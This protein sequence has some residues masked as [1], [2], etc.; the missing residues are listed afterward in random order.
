MK[1]ILDGSHRELALIIQKDLTK[2]AK[3]NLLNI[4]TEIKIKRKLIKE[5]KRKMEWQPKVKTLY[6]EIVAGTPET[7]RPIVGPVVREAAEKKC[8][9]RNGNAVAEVDL[10][11][12]MFEVTPP[13]FQDMM[14]GDLI[15]LGVDLDKYL[16]KIKCTYKFNTDLKQLV[17]QILKIGELI[18]VNCDEKAIWKV[19]NAYKD[20]Y[21]G[22]TVT[23]RTTT[24]PKEKRDISVRYLEHMIP[25]NPDPYTTAINEDLIEKNGEPIHM[26]FNEIISTF[27]ILGWGVDLDVRKGLS[28]IWPFIVPG[29]FEPVYSMSTIPSS[30]KKHKDYFTRHGLNVF[31][32]FGLDFLNN[33]INVYFMIK[34][35]SK[36][37]PEKYG[38]L[39]KELGFELSSPEVMNK[40][41]NALTIYY[42]FSWDTDRVERICFG[43]GCHEK[44]QVPVNFHPLIKKFVENIPTITGI[45]KFIYSITFTREGLFFK[46]ENDYTE[47]MIELLSM[48]AQAGLEV[49]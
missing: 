27:E 8:M 1:A 15:R 23:I 37:T 26:M 21:T 28:K 19:L 7:V 46:V 10:V 35:P 22:S 30:I 12:A 18:E 2:W 47:S 38:N 49:K 44:R 45:Q 39:L 33:T 48:G 25:H 34:D 11:I 5:V 6:E 16:A 9:E 24:K 42:T 13:A 41:C 40:C 4:K 36:A 31:S 20:F 43:I 17:E 3:F 29:P 32:V 14:K